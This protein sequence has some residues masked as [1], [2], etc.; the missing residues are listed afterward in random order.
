MPREILSQM[1]SAKRDS[2][3]ELESAAEPDFMQALLG[4]VLNT[5]TDVIIAIDADRSP[6]IWIEACAIHTQRTQMGRR[7][8][9]Q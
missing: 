7:Q 2:A 6:V 1:T 5:S 9:A 4:S 3:D 8:Y